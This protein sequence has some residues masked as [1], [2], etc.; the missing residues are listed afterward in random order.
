M[1][2]SVNTVA[3]TP[4]RKLK[5]RIHTSFLSYI[6]RLWKLSA[7]NQVSASSPPTNMDVEFSDNPISSSNGF[8][9]HSASHL[10]LGHSPSTSGVIGVIGETGELRPG[11]GGI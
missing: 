4:T 11:G 2:A 10:S 9:R 5:M 8:V 3:R 6:H 1:R 7:T